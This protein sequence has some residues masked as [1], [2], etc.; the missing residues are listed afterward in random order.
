MQTQQGKAW[1]LAL[2]HDAL[3]SL[4]DPIMLRKSPLIELFGLEQRRNIV[5][6]LCQSLSNAI[7]SLQPNAN[8][9][10]DSK[11]WRSYQILRRRYAEKVMQREVALDLGLSTRQLQR[12][13]AQARE[14]LADYLWD[15]FDLEAKLRHLDLRETTQFSAGGY[16]NTP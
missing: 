8:T 2:V 4:Y 1:F 16:E 7:E 11:V 3:T 14:T 12:A 9:P 5:L 13:E 6:S 10:R 15:A